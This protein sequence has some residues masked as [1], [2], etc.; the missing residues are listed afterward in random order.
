[1]RLFEQTAQVQLV[2]VAGGAFNAVD[3]LVEVQVRRDGLS[4]GA[5]AVSGLAV[6]HCPSGDKQT[7]F[8]AFSHQAHGLHETVLGQ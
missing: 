1:M 4:D 7:E 8:R 2:A 3:V 6:T 5:G